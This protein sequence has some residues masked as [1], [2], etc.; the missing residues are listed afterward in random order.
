MLVECDQASD[1][2][3]GNVCCYHSGRGS[4]GVFCKAAADC[5]ENANQQYF[6]AVVCKSGAGSSS[7]PSGACTGDVTG[8]TGWKYC[9]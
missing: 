9:D 5:V 6:E 7:C 1:C 4:S 2:P 3:L 8:V